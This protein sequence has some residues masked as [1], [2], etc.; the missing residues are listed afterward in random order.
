MRGSSSSASASGLLQNAGAGHAGGRVCRE[1]GRSLDPTNARCDW[2]QA[3]VGELLTTTTTEPMARREGAIATGN[4]RH[5]VHTTGEYSN[6]PC[7]AIPP[8]TTL[9]NSAHVPGHAF[10]VRTWQRRGDSTAYPDAC[11]PWVDEGR[12]LVRI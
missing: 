8:T 5:I 10:P 3:G 12:Y 7:P 11:Q 1:E 9:R 2:R 6:L 4:T